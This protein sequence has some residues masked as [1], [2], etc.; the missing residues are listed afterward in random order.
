MLFN[1]SQTAKLL[2][3][4]SEMTAVAQADFF[5]LGEEYRQHPFCIIPLCFMRPIKAKVSLQL[6]PNIS[7][8]R[9][10][11]RIRADPHQANPF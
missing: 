7:P 6:V 2:V 3:S 1:Q 10:A 9:S 4:G 5:S 8:V 11:R